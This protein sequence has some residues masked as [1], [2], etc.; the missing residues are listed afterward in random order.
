MASAEVS[1]GVSIVAVM[2]PNAVSTK[3]QSFEAAGGS[4]IGYIATNYGTISLGTVES[5]IS[6]YIQQFGD[7][8]EGFFIDQMS[9]VPATLSYY[10]CLNAFIKGLSPSYLTVGNPGQPFLNGVTPA[11]Y[12]SVADVMTIFEG[13]DTAATTAPDDAGFNHYPYAPN[14]F[15]TEPTQDIANIVNGT[16][17]IAALNADIDK[18]AALNAGYVYV[19]DLTAAP[20]VDTYG[21]L[22][23]YWNAEVAALAGRTLVWTGSDGTDFASAASWNDTTSELDPATLAPGTFDT[24]E[25]NSNAG[26]I[27]GTGT[28]AGMAFDDDSSWLMTSDAALTVT[29]SITVGGSKAAS[30]LING[31]A[32]L[33]SSGPSGVVI[34][35]TTSAAGS[36]VEVAGSGSELSVA[37]LLDVALAGSGTLFLAGGAHITAGSFV[38]AVSAS[39]VGN[40]TVTDPGTSLTITNTATV[41]DDGTG[42]LSVLNGATFSA[43]GLTIG[44]QAD[45]SGALVVSG[46][47][48]LLSISGELNIGTAAG[49]GDLTVGPGASVVA[50][51]VNLQGGVVNEGGFLD[52]TVYIENG[53]STTSGNGTIASDFILLEGTI[54]S[55]GSKAGKSTEVLQGTIVGGGTST[56]GGTTSVNTPGILQMASRDT[57]EVTGAVL[58]A[59]TT[60]FT[61]NLTPTGTYTVINSVIDVVFQDGTGVLQLDDIAGFGGTIATWH[62]GGEIIVTG[63]TL[64]GLG[65]TN[66]NTLTVDDSGSG[67]HAGGVDTIIFGSA[68]N[69]DGFDIINGNTIIACFAE[70][71]CIETISG[72]V[73]VEKLRVG[74]GLVTPHEDEASKSIVWIGQRKVN[75]RAH[76][77]PQTV[78]PV[79]VSAGAFGENV[80]RR[81]LYLSPDHAV[82]V[83]DVLVPVK[84]LINGT[85][86]TQVQRPKV[87]Y[88]HVE[89]PR[90][91]V[92]LAEGLPVESYLDAGDRVN[93]HQGGETIRLF[94]DFAARLTPNAALLWETRGAAPLILT[95]LRR[96]IP[97]FRAKM[98]T[99]TDT[100]L[101]IRAWLLTCAR[102]SR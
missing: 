11:D 55:N 50:S 85:S 99:A 86:I 19:T 102:G 92:I 84:L 3:I 9:V 8:V 72:F 65:L 41:A 96:A 34:A 73:A 49:T 12:L 90:H 45:S 33:S 77:A 53:G 68:I 60:T 29:G 27:T 69:A 43:Q 17:T 51:V 62:S 47:G 44:S 83:N 1:T 97:D 15:Q 64:S 7:L 70:G 67:A 80:P 4:V 20:G 89:L 93:F 82:F 2:D 79:R 6:T 42:V 71:T 100:E 59:A 39:A 78:W 13:P 81:D 32:S 61:D 75:C 52:P 21:E 25:F 54:L 10:Q 76:P 28:V 36:S 5:Q 66:G 74:D 37:G 16:P 57:I 56:I 48:S 35:S 88:Y 87:T 46:A 24:V 101:G 18:A 31:G 94:P 95:G 23:P 40:I 26:A 63:G 98:M 38:A 91:A 58:N 30:L 14:W 22:P